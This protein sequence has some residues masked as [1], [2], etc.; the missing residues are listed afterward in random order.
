MFTPQPDARS[1][2]A[3]APHYD[4]D[5]STAAAQEPVNQ[6]GSAPARDESVGQEEATPAV[7]RRVRQAV[8]L[9]REDLRRRWKVAD[10]ARLV[11][12][13]PDHLAS[14]FKRD[15]GFAPLQFLKVMRLERARRLLAETFEGVGKVAE[16]V[17]YDPEGSHFYHDFKAKYDQ[18]PTAYRQ[19]CGGSAAS[20]K[21]EGRDF[22]PESDSK[23][24]FSTLGN[25]TFRV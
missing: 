3:D 7:D 14:L 1:G 6:S 19:R 24:R 11:R 21:G 10:L 23:S 22:T 15:T 8:E 2:R 16:A 4:R 20:G 5:G 18:T 13:G 17:G 9:M 12:L 25:E